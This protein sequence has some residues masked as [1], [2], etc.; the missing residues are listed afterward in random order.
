MHRGS[1][2]IGNRSH[3]SG[4]TGIRGCTAAMKG[5]S[6]LCEGHPGRQ[7]GSRP[8]VWGDTTLG[9]QVTAIGFVAAALGKL[10]VKNGQPAGSAI[11]AA[12]PVVQISQRDNLGQVQAGNGSVAGIGPRYCWCSIDG[13]ILTS[14][15]DEESH[16]NF[17]IG[18]NS[19]GFPAAQTTRSSCCKTT[20]KN[21]YQ[22]MM[23]SVIPNTGRN[24]EFGCCG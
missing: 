20:I 19:S 1:S 14:A 2:G 3:Q 24:D 23:P 22:T 12:G 6:N 8:G 4:Y 17:T 21:V 13:K 7:C 5:C 16:I 11:E 10:V 15:E 18:N 9:E